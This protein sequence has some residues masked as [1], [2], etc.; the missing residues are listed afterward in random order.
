MSISRTARLDGTDAATDTSKSKVTEPADTGQLNPL[1]LTDPVPAGRLQVDAP[2]KLPVQEVTVTP[3][4]LT[5][6]SNDPS[7]TVMS[8]LPVPDTLVDEP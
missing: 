8:T 7:V 2:H 5:A 1:K 4:A 3:K 6:T